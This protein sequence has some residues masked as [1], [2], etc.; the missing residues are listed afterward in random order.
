M[1]AEEEAAI[2]A[3]IDAEEQAAAQHWS[4]LRPLV[5]KMARNMEIKLQKHDRDRGRRG[6]LGADTHDL[7]RGL[8]REVQE[9][10]LALEILAA[11][12]RDSQGNARDTDRLDHALRQLAGEAADVANFAAFVADNESALD[13]MIIDPF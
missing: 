1:N 8:L 12:P 10:K 4:S 2:I 5:Q 3:E 7:Y 9:L 6:W 13:V 11:T